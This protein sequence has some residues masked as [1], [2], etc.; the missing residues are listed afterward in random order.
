MQI[1]EAVALELQPYNYIRHIYT[2][3]VLGLISVDTRFFQKILLQYFRLFSPYFFCLL[4]LPH[5]S[6]SLPRNIASLLCYTKLHLCRFDSAM[7]I[8]G[9]PKVW[10]W[11]R[12]N[13]TRET[14]RRGQKQCLARNLCD[15]SMF[16]RSRPSHNP[17]LKWQ[18]INITGSV[19]T[20]Y[21]KQHSHERII[22]GLIACLVLYSNGNTLT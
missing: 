8:P 2:I 18:H 21:W 9:N 11:G 13:K 16:A 4:S 12:L 10:E 19:I 3:S 20:R 7:S 15:L 6:A 22:M 14:C 5:F 17:I 1:L